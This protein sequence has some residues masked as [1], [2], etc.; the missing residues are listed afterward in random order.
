MALLQRVYQRSS[1]NMLIFASG[2]FILITLNYQEAVITFNLKS[3][4]L[5]GFNAFILLGLVRV[6]DMGTGVNAQIIGTSNYWKFE[7][8]SGAIL[9]A[10]MLPLTYFLTIEYDI[11]GPAIANLISITIYNIVRIAFLWKK[12]K[13]FP[14]SMQS[15]YTVLLAAACFAICHFPF[16]NLH[17]FTGLII[18]SIVFI[19]LYSGSVIYLKL[20]PD[21]IPVWQ[22]I[23]KKLGLKKN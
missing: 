7:L 10:L 19:I 3:S 18:R 15:V 6:I 23:Q 11:L 21:V 13:L 16:I 14:F 1:L 12:F 4:Y 8:F 2:I 22:T 20:S 5:A 9:L 17:G